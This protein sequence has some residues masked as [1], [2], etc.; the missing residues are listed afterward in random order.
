MK[1]TCFIVAGPNGAGKST[2]AES[3]LPN[4]ANCFYFVNADMIA[5]G[6]SPLRPENAGLE[7]G[8]ILFRKIEEYSNRDITFAFESTLSGTGYLRRIES[9]KRSVDGG[10]NASVAP[11][12]NTAS[13]V[14]FVWRHRLADI[15]AR[16]A[17]PIGL[18]FAVLAIATGALW[19]KVTWGVFWDWDPRMTSM[20]VL[21]LLYLGYIAIW[22][23]MENEWAAAR[24]AALLAMLG[25]VNLP[26]IKFSVDWWD[27][28]HQT[29]TVVRQG[30]PSMPAS[31]LTPL[32]VMTAGYTALFAFVVLLRVHTA[33]ASR[34]KA[35][36][37]PKVS[38]VRLEE[39]S[40]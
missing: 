8:K 16:E 23:T 19:G 30:G 14:G 27:S 38:T 26:I 24:S 2:F 1:K 22:Q 40:S 31:M 11:I 29:A 34:R 10:A 13:L 18:L 3:F 6:L 39:A 15:A 25:A 33:L 28:L 17:A 7:A 21:V 9:L 20:L 32:L 4:E 35:A 36:P 37:A 5:K 12:F